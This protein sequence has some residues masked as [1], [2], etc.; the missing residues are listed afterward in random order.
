[1]HYFAYWQ[2]PFAKRFF[3]FFVSDELW[4]IGYKKITVKIL[5][6]IHT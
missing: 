6:D 3:F 4:K 1:M 5:S 2:F